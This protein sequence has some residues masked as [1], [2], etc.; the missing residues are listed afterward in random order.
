VDRL[1]VDAIVIRRNPA[2]DPAECLA[3]LEAELYPG[4]SVQVVEPQRLRQ[5]LARGTSEWLVFLDA[6]DKPKP[7]FLDIL[8]RAQ[9]GSGASVV[10]CGIVV[11]GSGGATPTNHIFLGE[12]RGLGILRNSYG[13]VALIRR[14]LVT[15]GTAQTD[16][17]LLATLSASGVAIVSVPLPLVER[18]EPP[19]D[20]HREPSD[21]LEVVRE[22]EQRL[23]APVR[24]LA[25]LAAG[26]AAAPATDDPQKDL[27]SRLG[28][29]QAAV[30]SWVARLAGTLGFGRA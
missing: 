11:S 27:A 10:T 2:H 1:R 18:A 8:A 19:D 23:P 7:G 25:E 17:T 5:A 16:W 12:P 4:L 6:C 28:H 20:L 30:G 13:T 3:A 26:L 22:L 24:S 9:A 15:G 29:A 21:A 14:A